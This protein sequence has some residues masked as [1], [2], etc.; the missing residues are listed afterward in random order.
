[1]QD[2]LAEVRSQLEGIR[3]RE[4]WADLLRALA[5][6]CRALLPAAE[7]LAVDARDAAIAQP[8][9]D[10]WGVELETS[11]AGWGGVV[12][13]DG[14]GRAVRNT[15]EERLANL[16]DRARVIVVSALEREDDG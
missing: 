14:H 7:R 4:D 3:G 2:A 11:Y 6:E 10:E 8:L 15:L 1:M 13:A 9:A 12:L 16:T 5:E